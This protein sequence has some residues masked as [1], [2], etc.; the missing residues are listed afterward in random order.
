MWL[1][2][3]WTE[4]LMDMNNKQTMERFVQFINS[5]NKELAKELISTN[6]LFF[7]PGQANPLKGPSGYID[8][9]NMMRS[10]FP[11]IQW[12]LEDMISEDDKIAARFT[13][14][15]T[16]QGVFLG[17]PATG[18]S[19]EVRA[20]NFY[21]F[22]NGQIIEEFGQPDFLALLQQIGALQS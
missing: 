11:D 21:L 1:I 19:I 3:L 5:A 9:I 18:K 15:G 6:A 7:V 12:T 4:N 17:I 16:H 20:I 22:S 14:R 13:M 2:D 8:I 10:G